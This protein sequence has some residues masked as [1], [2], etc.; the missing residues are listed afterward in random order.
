M[1]FF[2]AM[3]VMLFQ[4]YLLLG[5]LGKGMTLGAQPVAFSKFLVGPSLY[6]YLRHVMKRKGTFTRGQMP[7]FIPAI[8]S[9]IM[10]LTVGVAQAYGV[11]M[12]SARARFFLVSVPYAYDFAGLFSIFAYMAVIFHAAGIFR[13][14]SIRNARIETTFV[15]ILASAL[16][17][18]GMV[19]YGLLSDDMAFFRISISLVSLHIISW[20]IIGLRYPEFLNLMRREI[21]KS[22][23]ERSLLKNFDQN[24]LKERLFDLMETEKVYYNSE[25]SLKSLAAKLLITPHQLSELLNST[26]K[27]NFNTIVNTYRVDEAKRLMGERPGESIIK[28][29]FMVGFNTQSVFYSAFHKHAGMSP[30]NYRETALKKRDSISYTPPSRF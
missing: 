27:M 5:P 16:V 11:S 12:E 7:H 2:F 20:L 3:A 21:K 10:R 17:V 14:R 28:I 30:A 25:L 22:Q 4:M 9:V 8:I 19:I 29:A 1:L 13:M 6:L 23:Y 24:V 26:M 15:V 18:A